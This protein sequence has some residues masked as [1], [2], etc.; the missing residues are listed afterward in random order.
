MKITIIGTGYVGLVTGTCLAEVGND[1]LCLDVDARKIDI[2]KAGGV[3]IHEP[4]LEAII[5]RNVA[6]GRLAF[7]TDVDAAVAHGQ[8]QFIAVGTPPDEDGSADMQ[9]VI[10][11]ARNI[12]R[13]MQGFKIVVDK[14]TVPVG[15]ADRVRAAIAEELA[16]RGVGAPVR[17]GLESRVPE[18]GRRG[19]RLHEARPHRRR[20]RR[21][22]RDRRDARRLRAVHA[23]PRA[24][25]GDGRALG[26]AHQV[27]GQRD[28]G[29][30]DLVH[31]RA[32]QPRRGPRRRHRARPAGHRLRPADRLPL[33]LPGRRLRRLVL[34]QGRQGAAAHRDASTGGRCGCSTP[35]R[36]PTTRRSCGWS[37]RSSPGWARI[38]P[39]AG[40]RSGGSPS[41]PTPTTCARR[42][43]ARS[44]PRWCSAARPSWPT[45]RW[46]WTRPGAIFGAGAVDRV[47][48]LADG[49]GR[50]RR[51]A[52]HRH[53][54]EGVPQPR[55][56]RA[57]ALRSAR[58]WCSTAATCSTRRWSAR[59]R[60]RVL[61]DRAPLMAAPADT[62]SAPGAS[63]SPAR[64]CWSSAT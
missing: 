59:R 60:A 58:R 2:L 10:A 57:G 63:G 64:G 40:S 16:A 56:R 55:L 38:S 19:R 35:S 13:R 49:G 34:P 9:Y 31:E 47:R 45:T 32:R 7:T 18:G 24:A 23:Q 5:R 54:V 53:R 37:R 3:P 33:P 6:A 30:A 15:T 1:V 36:P 8:M 25:A 4:G 20:R 44:S 42:R 12:G 22:A 50:G 26:R 62:S 46:R 52:R 41:S 61:R 28:A 11:A 43:R 29:D 21:R 39:G 27:R 14:S 17:R 51:R 48:D